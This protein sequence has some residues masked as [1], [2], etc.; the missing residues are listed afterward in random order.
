MPAAYKLIQFLTKASSQ[1][2]FASKNN[3]LPTRRSAY[4]NSAVKSNPIISAFLQQMLVARARP[5]LPEGGA[6]YTDFTPNVQKVQMPPP[7]RMYFAST[8]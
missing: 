7:T 3:L 4:Q 1:A 2:T 6:I 8:R 5:V